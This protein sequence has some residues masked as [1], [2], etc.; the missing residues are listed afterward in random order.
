[1]IKIP[2]RSLYTILPTGSRIAHDSKMMQFARETLPAA[3]FRLHASH[4][5]V[6]VRSGNRDSGGARVEE[7]PIPWKEL[8]SRLAAEQRD[9]AACESA[10]PGLLEQRDAAYRQLHR[11][12]LFPLSWF[13]AFRLDARERRLAEKQQAVE[14]AAD[15]LNAGVPIVGDFPPEIMHAYGRLVLALDRLRQASRLWTIMEARTGTAEQPLSGS[16][17]ARAGMSAGPV[18]ALD[19]RWPGFALRGGDGTEIQLHPGFFLRQG[20]ATA[21]AMVPVTDAALTASHLHAL[22]AGTPPPD[23]AVTGHSWQWV[24]KD[25]RPDMRYTQ[26]PRLTAVRYGLLELSGQGLGTY[27]YVVSNAAIAEE[28]ALAFAAFRSALKVA[29]ASSTLAGWQP[30]KSTTAMVSIPGPPQVAAP[31]EYWLAP[32]IG[33]LAVAFLSALSPERPPVRPSTVALPT[34]TPPPEPTPALSPPVQ[35][36][37]PPTRELHPP[38]PVFTPERVAPTAI[39]PMDPVRSAEPAND[40]VTTR[41]GANVRSLPNGSG[42]VLRAVPAGTVLRVHARSGGWVRVGG[43]EPWGWVHSS[44]LEAPR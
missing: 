38:S 14:R 8:A 4:G 1:M 34:E 32:L 28:I 21:P 22:E 31:H 43:E 30:T 12:R 24:T 27:R 23:A 26:N 19:A 37:A 7:Q 35:P 17:L 6:Q 20:P 41:V 2:G 18:R 15:R 36:D 13:C 44:L 9:R 39:R 5:T 29:N 25:G 42:D 10:L 11:N 40:Q 3:G 33:L 16:S